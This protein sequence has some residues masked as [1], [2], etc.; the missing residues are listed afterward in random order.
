MMGDSAF[1]YCPYIPLTIVRAAA[2]DCD[3]IRCTDDHG[4]V[5]VGLVYWNEDGS[6]KK[7]EYVKDT[8]S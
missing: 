8:V 3:F 1:Y 6:I 7:L 4:D 5:I 2:L